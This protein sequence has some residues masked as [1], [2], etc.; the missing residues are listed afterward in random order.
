MV[1]EFLID[2]PHRKEY[3]LPDRRHTMR[4]SIYGDTLNW[5]VVDNPLLRSW[6]T[7]L[8]GTIDISKTGWEDLWSL[9]QE[10]ADKRFAKPLQGKRGEIRYRAG[11]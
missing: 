8:S 3:W 11:F 5:S 10:L 4:V 6:K 9:A 7:V 2:T 1:R